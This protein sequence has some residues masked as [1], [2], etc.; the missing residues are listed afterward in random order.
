M[1]TQLCPLVQ[2]LPACSQGVSLGCG[3]ISRLHWGRVCF[4]APGLVGRIQPRQNVG[5]E[6][7]F[8]AGEPLEAA[9]SSWPQEPVHRVTPSTAACFIRARQGQAGKT[10]AKVLGNTTVEVTA[11]HSVY[12]VG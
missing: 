9:L 11:H 5:C 6:P 7:H 3:L 1:D 12:P 8:L 4:Q 10:Q 2:G